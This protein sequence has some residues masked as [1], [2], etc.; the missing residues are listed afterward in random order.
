[1]KEYIETGAS[2][3]ATINLKVAARA[4]AYLHGRGY[5]IPDDIKNC[6]MDVMRHRIRISY[7]AEA[8]EKNSETII[9]KILDELPVP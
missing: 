7:E 4:L 1:M 3:R 9:Q 6:A 2:P 8:E 5:V